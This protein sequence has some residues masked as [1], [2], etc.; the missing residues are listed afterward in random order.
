MVEVIGS[1]PTAPTNNK[2]ASHMACSFV[3]GGD[4]GASTRRNQNLKSIAKFN[5]PSSNKLPRTYLLNA[6]HEK[7]VRLWLLRSMGD[8]RFCR[9]PQAGTPRQEFASQIDARRQQVAAYSSFKRPPRKR[10]RLWRT[11][12]RGGSIFRVSEL[13]Y[14][15]KIFFYYCHHCLIKNHLVKFA[16]F[17]NCN[18]VKL[19]LSNN[20]K[21][22]KYCSLHIL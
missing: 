4:F 20:C 22:C 13:I 9:F 21:D 17:A 8:K 2:R 11:L 12:F 7:G 14:N 10:V 6:H 1:S 16:I 19:F 15:E 3:I 18:A 5:A